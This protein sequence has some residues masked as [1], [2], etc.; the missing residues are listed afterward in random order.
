MLNF[1][2]S[3]AFHVSQ[4]VQAI[5]DFLFPV[6]LFVVIFMFYC[7][8]F[9]DTD[10]VNV[11][12]VTDDVVE[13]SEVVAVSDDDDNFVH[14]VSPQENFFE[15]SAATMERY[16]NKATPLVELYSVEKE[17]KALRAFGTRTLKSFCKHYKIKGYSA[18]ANDGIAALAEFM[19]RQH[20]KARDVEVFVRSQVV[21]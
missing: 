20:V 4:Q 10:I 2:T 9:L 19:L 7:A 6:V 21:A 11:A 14:V 5:N 1:L 16:Q 13:N 3:N 15:Q 8:I 17:L 18:A 12:Y